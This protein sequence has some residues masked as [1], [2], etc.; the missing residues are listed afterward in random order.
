MLKRALDI[1]IAIFWGVISAPLALTIALVIK[2]ESPG[3]ALYPS[4]R[5]GKYGKPFFYYRFRTRVGMP[6]RYTRFGKFIGN[7]SLDE[8]PV[9]WN[10]LKGDL[11]LVGPR[12]EVPDKVDLN[13]PDWQKVLSVRPGLTGLGGLTLMDKYNQT[14]VKDRIQPEIYYVE[15][16]SFLMDV[17]ILIKTLYL[18][19]RMGHLKGRF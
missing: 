5:V 1:V 7:L 19:T 12:P 14:S 2:A 9:F 11:S 13:D 4:Q 10:I 17:R 8:M 16:R 15:H 18:W 6:P 3:P